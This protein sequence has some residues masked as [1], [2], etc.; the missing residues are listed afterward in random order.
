MD[1]NQLKFGLDTFGDVAIDSTGKQVS[2]EESIRNIAK[3]GQLAEEAGVDIFALG[4]H[5]RK[6]YSISS[7]EIILAALASVT[8]K[9]TLGTAVTVLSSDDPIRLYQRFA[10]L[11]ALSNGRSQVMI[12]RGSFTE[13]FG[14][15]GYDLRDYNELFEE[16]LALFDK[17]VKGGGEPVT[18]SGRF[19]PNLENMEVYPKMTENT[20]DVQVGVGGTPESVVRAARYGYPLMLAIIGGSPIRFKPYIELYKKSLDKFGNPIQPVGM[21]SHGVIAETDEEAI[22]RAWKYIVPAMNKLGRERGWGP[23]R[24]ETFEREVESGSYYVGSPETVANRM[25]NVIKEMGIER[26]DLVYGI[27]GQQQEER[28]QTIELYGKEVIPRV[29]EIL[30]EEN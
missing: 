22:E 23:M 4:E 6:E 24:R 5:H 27:N 29:K 13:S 17:L 9:I 25:A 12:G 18:S 15:F 3:E 16:K 10:T 11:D 14:L 2:Y 7:P 20:L 28:F 21:H 19:T 30:K 1:V 26:F 8:E